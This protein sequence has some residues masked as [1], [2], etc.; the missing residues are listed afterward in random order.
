ML[1]GMKV[2]TVTQ[3]GSL[4]HR[5]LDLY[6]ADI[7]IFPISRPPPNEIHSPPP[8][9]TPGRCFSE[10]KQDALPFLEYSFR[11]RLQHSVRNAPLLP[12]SIAQIFG[13]SC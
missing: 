12:Q 6:Q 3:C 1:T 11:C 4:E 9:T 13:N 7:E 10:S 8:K 5:A 2:S